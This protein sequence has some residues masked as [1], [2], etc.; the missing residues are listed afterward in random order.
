MSLLTATD[1]GHRVIVRHR[2]IGDRDGHGLTDALGVLQELDADSLLVRHAGGTVRR[3]LIADVV[4]AKPIPPMPLRRV[5]LDRLLLTT[6]LGRPAVETQ[7]IGDW[8]LRASSGW[9]GRANSLLPVGEP[10]I[11]LAEA[12][13]R[14]A[15]FY[16]TRGLPPLALVRLGSSAAA[17]LPALGWVDARPDQSDALVLHTSLD[18]I[19]AEPRYPV[20]IGSRPDQEW[21]AVAFDGE[22][23]APARAVMEGAPKPAFAAIRLDGQ[24]VAVGRG[25]IT[26]PW[27]GI[28]GVRVAGAHRRRGLG[29]AVLR[30]LA[31]WAGTEGGRRSYLEV[32]QQNTAALNAYL[33]LGYTEAYRYRY[34][35]VR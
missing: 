27:L 11:P 23:G 1:V 28:D 19:N 32:L 3:I 2:L 29:T 18:V 26:G 24:I 31:R 22:P 25:S 16:R 13:A 9:T 12:L 34:L 35:T 21:Y 7:H 10:G 15:E 20:Q 6:A 4:A 33:G 30:G 17:D 8:L 14:T 5:D